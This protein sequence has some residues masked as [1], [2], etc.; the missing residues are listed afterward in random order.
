MRSLMADGRLADARRLEVGAL[1]NHARGPVA[2]GAVAAADH[3]GQRDG[4]GR[5]GDHQV[6]GIERVVLVVQARGIASPASGAA[7]ENGV[8][9][10]QVGDRRRAWAAPART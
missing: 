2:D 6:G 10:Q 7:D 1:Q 3:A 5:I 8:A 4:A 9:V